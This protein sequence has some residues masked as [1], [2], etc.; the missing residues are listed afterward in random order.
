[1]ENNLIHFP[2]GYKN[3]QLILMQKL[4]CKSLLMTSICSKFAQL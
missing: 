3:S 2:Q 1:M 4:K